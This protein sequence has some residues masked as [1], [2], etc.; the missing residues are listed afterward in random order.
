[1][2]SPI[3]VRKRIRLNFYIQYITK[4]YVVSQI[5]LEYPK[6]EVVYRLVV[7][8]LVVR[9]KFIV[10][11]RVL[12]LVLVAAIRVANF[13]LLSSIGFSVLVFGIV[14]VGMMIVAVDL[15]RRDCSKVDDFVQ[16]W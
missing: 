5:G 4:T 11:V 12:R 15:R 13:L 9:L 10:V 8:I 3:F 14:V 16:D 2:S 6:I 7:I 1:M